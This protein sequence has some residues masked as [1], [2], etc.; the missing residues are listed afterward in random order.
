MMTSSFRLGKLAGVEISMNISL[1][2]IAG[3]ITLSLSGSY[4]PL[5]LPG[6]SETLYLVLG[7]VT[8]LLFF[9]SIVWHEMA[10]A[11]T[12]RL[13][14]IPVRRIVL[15]I[16][17]GVAEIEEQPRKA[18]Q[19]FW[20]AFVGPLSSVVLGG[21]FLGIE[22]LVGE[23]SASG[24]ML[25]WLG[26]INIILAIFNMIP[27][28]PLDG[29]RVLRAVVWFVSGNYIRAT[30]IAVGGGRIFAVLMV[31]FALFD[32][33]RTGDM[34]NSLWLIFIAWFLW[35]T[36]R[37]QL[38]QAA[39]QD[40]LRDVPIQHAIP[41]RVEISPDWSLVYAMDVI[42]SNGAA[43]IAPVVQ[44]GEMIG[45]FAIDTVLKVPR[46]NW[47]ITRVRALM[48]SMS[49]IPTVN[50]GAD[51]LQTLRHMEMTGTDF[52]LVTN[53]WETLGFIGKY[54]LMHFATDQRQRA[55]TRRAKL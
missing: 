24:T 1:I 29:G 40:A 6:R 43:R 16:F 49:G 23:S 30:R 13:Y 41:H 9:S 48:K 44:Q 25:R 10:H 14:H 8:A 26:R 5:R 50:A 19:E 22:A 11:L 33:T 17:G 28:F 53:G 27:A 3:L 42:S 37:G 54:E 45:I 52:V 34:F 51:I 18:H 32:L 31:A 15:H 20:I 35:G 21:A 4:F 7:M 46:I 36:S 55:A 39:L 12:A 47:G 38:H 2:F